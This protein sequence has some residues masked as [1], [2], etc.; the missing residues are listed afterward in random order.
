M[1][2]KSDEKLFVVILKQKRGEYMIVGLDGLR[3]LA[4]LSFSPTI[5]I[6]L[7]LGG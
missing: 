5:P 6:I 3:A 2:D 4:F 1:T 7:D